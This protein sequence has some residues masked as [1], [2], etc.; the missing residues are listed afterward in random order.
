MIKNHFATKVMIGLVA[1]LAVGVWGYRSGWMDQKTEQEG[2]LGR[3]HSASGDT[4]AG[5][6][7]NFVSLPLTAVF[8]NSTTTDQSNA[9]AQLADGGTTITQSFNTDGMDWVSFGVAAKGGTATSTMFARLQLY[10]GVDWMELHTSSTPGLLGYNTSTVTALTPYGFQFD[11]GLAS[12]TMMSFRLPVTGSKTGR[13]IM[14]GEDVTTDPNDGVQAWV[15]AIK[16]EPLSS[17]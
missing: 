8:A 5:S 1:L 10:D 2:G 15:K 9:V 6:S 13:L 4:L 16:I 7:S 17:R 11:P 12:T 3:S 14:W